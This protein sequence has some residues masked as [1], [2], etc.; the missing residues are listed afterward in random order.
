MILVHGSCTKAFIANQL[1]CSLPTNQPERILPPD[2]KRPSYD[3]RADVWS[4]GITLV[5]LALGRYPY[6]NCR[7]DFELLTKIIESDPPTLPENSNF[8][9]YFRDFI[10]LCLQKD[11]EKRP[12]YK[13]LKVRSPRL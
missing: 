13:Y 8:S 1:F 4:L 7:G 3:I 2:P 9:D 10:R 5:Q 6:Q 12:K 11:V